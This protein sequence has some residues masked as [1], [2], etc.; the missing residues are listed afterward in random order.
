MYLFKKAKDSVI[1]SLQYEKPSPLAKLNYVNRFILKF[2]FLVSFGLAAL[3]SATLFFNTQLINK[4]LLEFFALSS[5]IISFL[6]LI[7]L[8]RKH[9]IYVLSKITMYPFSFKELVDVSL[10][11]GTVTILFFDIALFYLYLIVE[12]LNFVIGLQFTSVSYIGLYIISKLNVF[13][14]IPYYPLEY[15]ETIIKNINGDVY[16]LIKKMWSFVF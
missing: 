4:N 7:I 12:L 16:I 14:T 2:T 8:K 10:T 11:T 13:K 3:T 15:I 5:I 9:G 6:C 1:N